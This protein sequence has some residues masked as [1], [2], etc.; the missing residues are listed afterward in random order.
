MYSPVWRQLRERS[1]SLASRQSFCHPWGLAPNWRKIRSS[2]S[3]Q[4]SV[5]PPLGTSVRLV[6]AV[7]NNAL[8]S[9]V[10][11]LGNWHRATSMLS[12][13]QRS[14]SPNDGTKGRVRSRLPQEVAMLTREAMTAHA[15]HGATIASW[16]GHFTG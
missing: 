13:M 12:G 16:R 5:A 1:R 2:E 14:F 11:G 10:A 4:C 6:L 7:G 8:G 3:P 9:N 15:G